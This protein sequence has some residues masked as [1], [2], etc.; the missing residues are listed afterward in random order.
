MGKGGA[1]YDKHAGMALEPQ[2]YPNAVNTPH[3]PSAVL[4]PGQIY[5]Q[6]IEY[7]FG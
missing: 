4:R 1:V 5:R 6:L 7:R 2:A 3:F